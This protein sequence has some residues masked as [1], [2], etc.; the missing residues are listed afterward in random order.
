M[1]DGRLIAAHQYFPENDPSAFDRVAVR[2][3]TDEGKSWTKSG[4]DPADRLARRHAF[5]V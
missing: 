3:S 5:S 1:P 2:F 4:D